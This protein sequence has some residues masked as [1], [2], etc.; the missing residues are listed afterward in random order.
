MKKNIYIK[1]SFCKF[2]VMPLFVIICFINFMVLGL[3][4]FQVFAGDITVTGDDTN[5]LQISVKDNIRLKGKRILLG[6]IVNID[7]C[8][9]SLKK[10]INSVQL[11][12]SPGLGKEKRLS[13][14]TIVASLKRKSW[15]PDNARISLPD[16]IVVMRDSQNVLN[17]KLRS[18][19]DDYIAGQINEFN[20]GYT[21]ANSEGNGFRVSGFR[22]HGH[23]VFPGGVLEFDV[24][25]RGAGPVRGRV[26]L[27]V[28]VYVD[29]RECGKI[30]LT[31]TVHRTEKV[32]CVKRA[33]KRGTVLKWT[34]LSLRTIESSA[35]SNDVVTEK[36]DI[37]GMCL[38]QSVRGG[39]ILKISMLKAPFAI[40]RGDRVKLVVKSGSLR[41]VTLGVAKNNAPL[42]GQIQVQNI[43]SK[44][45]VTGRVVSSSTV[46]VLL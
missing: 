27:S 45:L 8:S 36:S 5:S 3:F 33:L 11:G 28:I 9:D 43:R 30:S 42:N 25:R 26:S 21:G 39:G 40:K 35:G 32:V 4:T 31:G 20:N 18:L 2:L 29:G 41:V 23:R 13:N 1:N 10:S 12:R 22:S 46:E 16:S 14:R 15:F 7:N 34:D 37:V 44:K 6:D 19:F 38:R 24:V 17:E